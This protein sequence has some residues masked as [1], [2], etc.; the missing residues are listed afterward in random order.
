MWVRADRARSLRFDIDSPNAT[1]ASEGI[2]FG[3]DVPL[4]TE[5]AQVEVLFADAAMPQWAFDQGRAPADALADI[6][7]T[8]TGLAFFPQCT[9]VGPTG[10]LPEGTTDPGFFEVDDIEFF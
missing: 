7:A 8:T 4:T 10:L 6:L 1:A 9:G 2:R 5:A 3:W